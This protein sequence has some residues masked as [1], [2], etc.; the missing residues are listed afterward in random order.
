MLFAALFVCCLFYR[1]SRCY[2]FD[3]AGAPR[4]SIL[5][6]PD[7]GHSAT[8]NCFG[9]PAHYPFAN[10]MRISIEPK[11]SP[12]ATRAAQGF[13]LWVR[14]SSGKLNGSAQDMHGQLA[15]TGETITI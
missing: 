11:R 7:V 12:E 1:Q 13:T 4:A 5:K 10:F 6:F 3:R 2:L 15:P 8:Q 9:L 14:T